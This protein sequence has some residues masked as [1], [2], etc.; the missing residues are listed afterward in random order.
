MAGM[1][2]KFHRKGGG[3]MN[4]EREEKAEAWSI[5]SMTMT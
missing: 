1:I 3:E 2:N 5:F 4:G